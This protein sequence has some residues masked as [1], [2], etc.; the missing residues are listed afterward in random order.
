[1]KLAIFSGSTRDG[2]INRKLERA[3]LPMLKEAGFDVTALS[4]ADYDMPIYNGDWE[5]KNGAPQAAKD[6]GKKL[7]A[8]DAVIVV[9]PEYNGSL[10]PVLKNTIDWM[11]RIDDMS[12]YHNPVWAIAACT[13]GPMSGIM[14]MR[15][16]HYILT[17]L[18]T[19]VLQFQ[20]GVGNAS[21]A[22][23]DDGNLKNERNRDMAQKMISNLAE[24]AAK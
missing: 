5:E 22:F 16:V 23:D 13:P 12:Q 24:R 10:P 20:L 4:L 6:L 8:Q 2:S 14:V 18:G 1:M 19:E 3:L 17:R 11:T 7:A 9:T 21:D 15:Q